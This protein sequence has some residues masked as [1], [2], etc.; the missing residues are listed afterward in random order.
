MVLVATGDHCLHISLGVA[1]MVTLNTFIS[2]A[3]IV[4]NFSVK[5]PSSSKRTESRVLKRYLYTR[6]HSSIIRNS[7]EAEATRVH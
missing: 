7:Q 1:K 5:K 4:W 6:V 2:S 3:F